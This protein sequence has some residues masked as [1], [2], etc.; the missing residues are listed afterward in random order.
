MNIKFKHLRF[1]EEQDT[2]ASV[3]VMVYAAHG[4]ETVAYVDTTPEKTLDEPHTFEYTRA[5][6]HT[7]E[8]FNKKIGRDVSAGRLKAGLGVSTVTCAPRDLYNRVFDL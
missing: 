6:C 3:P 1:F 2:E 8:N 7:N 4:G 5:I